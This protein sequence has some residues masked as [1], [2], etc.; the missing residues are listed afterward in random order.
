MP[1]AMPGDKAMVANGTSTASPAAA[2]KGGAVSTSSDLPVL[3]LLKGVS[4]MT[5]ALLLNPTSRGVNLV[6]GT[7]DT[8]VKAPGQIVREI[9]GTAPAARKKEARSNAATAVQAAVRGR[10][11]RQSSPAT[12][13]TKGTA[14]GTEETEEMV[15]VTLESTSQASKQ[16]AVG[17][18][19]LLL[20]FLAMLS[21]ALLYASS[22]GAFEPAAPAVPIKPKFKLSFGGKKGQRSESKGVGQI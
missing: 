19:M 21:S 5:D 7:L 22:I 17:R 1:G 9:D 20:S 14:G 13:P 8:A 11:S 2:T 16:R 10:I 3:G 6:T 18:L 12:S 15:Q 4:S